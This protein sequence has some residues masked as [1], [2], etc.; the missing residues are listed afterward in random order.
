VRAIIE[1]KNEQKQWTVSFVTYAP[2]YEIKGQS[3]S[4]NFQTNRVIVN[5]KNPSG[6]YKQLV[7]ALS[8]EEFERIK[9]GVAKEKEKASVPNNDTK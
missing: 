8:A 1:S 6:K 4:I 2:L 3:Y 9:S 7:S 5:F